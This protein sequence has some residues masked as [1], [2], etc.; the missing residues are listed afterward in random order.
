M[1]TNSAKTNEDILQIK[2]YISV[3]F[4]FIR[5]NPSELLFIQDI[6]TWLDILVKTFLKFE[7]ADKELFLLSHILR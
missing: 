1:V 4:Y 7:M 3:L 2:W 6:K 5:K